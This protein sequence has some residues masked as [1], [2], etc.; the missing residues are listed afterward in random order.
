MARTDAVTAD[1][2]DAG[3]ARRHR[4]ARTLLWGF[5]RVF[6]IVVLIVAWEG[7]ARS[8]AFTPFV[9]PSLCL[10]ARAHLDRCDVGRALRSTPG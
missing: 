5:A 1:R 6:S 9:L 3:R 7:L 4:S 2:S 10:G 8:G